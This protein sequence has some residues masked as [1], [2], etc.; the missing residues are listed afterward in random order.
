MHRDNI[1]SD[2]INKAVD[3]TQILWKTHT[4]LLIPFLCFQVS[5]QHLYFLSLRNRYCLLII[6]CIYFNFLKILFILR[7]REEGREKEKDRNID[8]REKHLWVASCT[9]GSC[10]CPD[11][12]PNQQPRHVPWLAIE[13]ATTLSFAGWDPT[14]WATLVR[15]PLCI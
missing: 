4:M 9:V 3:F 6:S 14:N 13:Q 10:T 2:N 5:V 7:E 11:P 1:F 12:G 8:A 15:S